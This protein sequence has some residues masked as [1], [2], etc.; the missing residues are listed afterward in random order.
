MPMYEF[1]CERCGT[2]F[3]ELVRSATRIEDVRCPACGT[4]EVERQVSAAAVG[5]GSSSS[6][7]G[8]SGASGSCG[9]SGF[10]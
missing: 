2:R 10:S 6:G 7:G 9:G 5:G 4:A 3:E 8:S 1:Q